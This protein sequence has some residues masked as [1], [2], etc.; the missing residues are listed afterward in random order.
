M[1]SATLTLPLLLTLAFAQGAE[2]PTIDWPALLMALLQTVLT[3]AGGT[4]ATGV[5]LWVVDLI[6]RAVPIL[7]PFRELLAQWLLNLIER[8]KQQRAERVVLQVGQ[9]YKA[10]A[11]TAPDKAPLLKQG[12][13]T[14]ARELLEQRGIAS[15][16]E[17]RRIIE[18]VVGK[19]KS[20]GVNP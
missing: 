10:K 4:L 18:Q 3:F 13:A 12:R 5:V 19:L 16:E 20:E 2:F 1:R 6:C 14:N 9:E 8:A 17:A 11:A 15:G 7:R